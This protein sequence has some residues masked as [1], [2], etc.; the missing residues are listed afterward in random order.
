MKLSRELIDHSPD[1]SPHL[2]RKKLIVGKPDCECG[3]TK[4]I[5]HWHCP[6]CGKLVGIKY[7]NYEK[8]IGTIYLPLKYP[9]GGRRKWTK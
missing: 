4:G 6:T 2:Y 3:E 7:S 1:L 9:S 8:T 5:E